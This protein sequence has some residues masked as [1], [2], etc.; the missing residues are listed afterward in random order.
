MAAGQLA[1]AQ[2]EHTLGAIVSPI[3]GVVL[4]APENLG[5][6]VTPERALFEIAEPLEL[7]RV[8]VDVS[9]ADIGDVRPGQQ[10]TFEVQT[11][12]GRKFSGRVE[13]VGV[14]SKREGSVVTYPVRLLADN[15]DR[16]LL[17]GMTAAV[18][19][20]VARATNVLA[21]REAALRFLPPG[22]EPAES[23]TRLFRRVGPAQLAAVAV[24]AGLS[25]GTYTEVRAVAPS[26]LSERD[27]IA[28][29]LLR[30]DAAERA[31]PGI[32]LGGK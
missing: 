11:F 14:E 12:P 18:A 10:T 22:F 19:L 5:S 1:S 21:V 24:A 28:V 9:E 26:T 32:S 15:R 30:A 3:D 17:P 27:E 25:D 13:R 4:T 23:R 20:E 7:M 6:A 8:D 31:Q 29:G 2:F 16:A